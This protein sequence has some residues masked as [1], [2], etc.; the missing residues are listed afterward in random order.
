[1]AAMVALANLTLG[2]A[3]ASVSFGSIPTTGYRDLRL[4]VNAATSAEGNIY[5]QV[6]SD[7][8]NNYWRVNMR[9]F[10]ASSTGSSHGFGGGSRIDSNYST[11]LQTTSRAI[12]TYDFMDYSATDKHKTILIRANHSDEV[13]ALA[14][15]WANTAAIT[16]IL[17]SANGTTTFTAGST[18]SL[19]GVVSA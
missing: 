6:N 13:D 5:I 15:R 14:G 18:F 12:N 3:Q 8:G 16:S 7:T 19:Y 4:V 2:S 1:M 9:G 10:G 11:G 17:V